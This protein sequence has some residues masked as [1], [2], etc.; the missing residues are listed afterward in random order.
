MTPRPADAWGVMALT[1]DGRGV[2]ASTPGYSALNARLPAALTMA[3]ELL[4][5]GR[6]GPGLWLLQFDDFAHHRLASLAFGRR[7]GAAPFVDLLPDPYFHF[8]GGYAPLRALAESG[9]LAPWEAREE[10]VFWRGR[11]T[12]NGWTADG[13][14]IEHLSQAPRVALAARLRGHPHADVAL[15]GGWL[16]DRAEEEEAHLA[17][18]GLLRPGLPMADHARYRFQI[19]IDGVA[20]AWG[21]MERFLCGSC[22]LKVGTPFEMW[23]YPMIRPWEHYVPVAADLSDLEARID[24]CLSHPRE[25]RAVAE[26]GQR[27]AL[28]HTFEAATALAVAAFERRRL[29]LEE[30]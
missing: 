18:E 8:S 17:A 19:D 25:A 27:F 13:A 11:P 3:R 7:A 6:P 24:W 23:F 29:P 1:R 9:G 5:R 20:N 15:I 28:S 2:R 14:W 4:G 21:S 16:P 30:D 26:A 10:V 12:H 22:V